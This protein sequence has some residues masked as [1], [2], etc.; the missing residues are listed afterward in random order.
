M[1]KYTFILS[2]RGGT[3]ISQ[4]HSKNIEVALIDWAKAININDIQYFGKASKIE[5]IE[6][7]KDEQPI[8]LKG[9]ENV[10]CISGVLKVGHFVGYVVQS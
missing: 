1:K 9:L 4:I 3:Y 8:L 7:M 2:F 6:L 10:W 5:L